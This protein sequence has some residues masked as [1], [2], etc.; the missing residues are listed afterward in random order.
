MPWGHVAVAFTVVVAVL[1]VSA[2]YALRKT[3]AMNLVE[4][5]RSD[6]M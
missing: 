4:A 6:V 5:L 2:G 3:H 1:A